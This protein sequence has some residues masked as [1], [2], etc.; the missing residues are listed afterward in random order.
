MDEIRKTLEAA[1][2]A[3]LSSWYD[4]SER[5]LS[6]RVGASQYVVVLAMTVTALLIGFEAII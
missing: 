4:L 2:Q 1:N 6:Y 3:P 5:L